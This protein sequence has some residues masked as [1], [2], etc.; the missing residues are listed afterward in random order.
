MKALSN[1]NIVKTMLCLTFLLQA[2][3]ALSSAEDTIQENVKKN[4]PHY[5]IKSIQLHEKSGLYTV[6]LANGPALYATSNGE[7]FLVGD[8]YRIEASGLIN[9]TEEAKLAQIEDLPTDEMVVFAAEN[10]KAHIS[11]FTDITCGYCRMLH[12]EIE[13]LNDLGITVRYLA[14]PRAGID[15]EPYEQ[16]V[17]I[18]CSD[19]PKNWMTKAKEGQRV[20]D[21]KCENP[22]AQHYSIGQSIG[23]RGTPTLVLSTGKLIPGYLPADKLAEELGL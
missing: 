6:E 23:V 19:S 1:F 13:Q 5:V 21:N 14:Y 16:M 15:S 3:F 18:W 9:E 17:N 10:E 12:T 2:S 11:V 22:V 20:P 8:L 7:Y 4:L